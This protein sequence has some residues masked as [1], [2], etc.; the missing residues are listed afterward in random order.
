MAG[1]IA[2][3]ASGRLAFRLVGIEDFALGPDEER[4]DLVFAMR[5]GAL[6]GRHPE[7][8]ARAIARL[9]VAL[10]EDGLLVIDGNAAR[11]GRDLGAI[12]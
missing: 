10:K 5:V 8:E 3:M 7:L 11:R 9:R 4:F 6:D 1:S 2:E 12:C